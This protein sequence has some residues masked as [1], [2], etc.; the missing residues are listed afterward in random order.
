[1]KKNNILIIISILLLILTIIYSNNRYIKKEKNTYQ[2][3]YY[4]IA[5]IDKYVVETRTR[6]YIYSYR[7]NKIKYH[8]Q[9]KSNGKLDKGI[10]KIVMFNKN[11]ISESFLFENTIIP[12]EYLNKD[13]IWTTPP[14]FIDP[15]DLNFLND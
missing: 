8:G 15:E 12:E 14:N 9:K 6:Y 13:T 11:K 7:F 10:K 5:N 2:N 3:A 1:M 4:T